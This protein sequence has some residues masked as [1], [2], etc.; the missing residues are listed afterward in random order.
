MDLI[1]TFAEDWKLRLLV[2]IA[3]A[4]MALAIWL[5]AQMSNARVAAVKSKRMVPEDFRTTRNEPDDVVVYTRA[6]ANQ[7]EAPVIFYAIIAIGLALGVSSWI[8]VILAALF[9]FFRV[10]HAREM[11]GEHVIL[12]RRKLFIYSFYVL[13]A[14]MAELA[15]STLLRA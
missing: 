11:I 4:Q 3:L 9:V 13:M 14:M 12:K 7:F 15:I 5:Y 1:W 8:T 6:V 2:L 10:R